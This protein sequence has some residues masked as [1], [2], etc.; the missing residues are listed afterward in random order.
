M[1]N[2]AIAR[3]R[4][5]L[6]KSKVP[7]QSLVLDDSI[8]TES[9]PHIPT[10]SL[11]LD[12][13]IG[14]RPN[15]SGV[16]PCPGWPRGKIIQLYGKEGAGK[17]TVALTACA[18]VASF[19][20]SA[21]YV[22]FEH[23]VVPQYAATL[24]VPVTDDEKFLLVQPD[25]LEEGARYIA[26][27]AAAGID[28]IVVDSV[29]SI[30]PK[31][32]FEQKLSDIGE[33]GRLGA[34]AAFWSDFL[35]KIKT[36]IAKSGTTLIGISQLRD[37]VNTGRSHGPDYKA[38][39]G[40]AWKFYPAIRMY[41]RPSFKE[42]EKIHNSLTHSTEEV[43]A[44]FKVKARLDKCKVSDSYYHEQEFYL[45]SGAGIDDLRSLIDVAEK[46][47]IIKKSGSW[48]TWILP[49]GEEIRTQGM[50]KLYDA[51][52][53]A[54]NGVEMLFQQVIPL[55]G[56]NVSSDDEEEHEDED[57]EILDAIE[58]SED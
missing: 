49:D 57:S 7:D 13:L 23:E 56:V 38:Q 50:S 28:L 15:K 45:R 9:L 32:L 10:G 53:E 54:D 34:V 26:A 37:A 39:G 55:L 52:Q 30:Q 33:S 27:F 4:A 36:V 8:F 46:H 12:Y 21:I 19:G 47:A 6:K 25:Y 41:L 40:N 48:Y 5:A 35:P 22:D 14:G 11:V 51:I 18:S 43:V 44:G 58:D 16:A 42:K 31:K 3:A 29:A 1:S 20:G 2:S 17:T 24:G